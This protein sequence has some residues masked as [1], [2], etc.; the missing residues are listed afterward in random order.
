VETEQ[1]RVLDRDELKDTAIRLLMED[2]G[3]RA[4][5][6]NTVVVLVVGVNAKLVDGIYFASV[7]RLEV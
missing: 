1:E 7:Y 5:Q 4:S 2:Y 6:H 3:Y